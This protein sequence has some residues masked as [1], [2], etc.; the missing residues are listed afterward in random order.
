MKS[1]KDALGNLTGSGYTGV[2][3]TSLTLPVG[4]SYEYTYN[5][6]HR[7]TSATKT[8]NGNEQTANYGYDAFG[9]PT[10][11]ALTA[12]GYTGLMYES[13]AYSSDGNELL[14]VTDMLNGTTSYT[15]DATT[16]LLS[17]VEDANSH[18]TGYI[19]DSRYRIQKIYNDKDS[20]GVADSNEESV[21]YSYTMNELSGI[22]TATTGYTLQH[23]PFGNL[24][25]VKAGNQT[26]ASYIYGS[27]NGKIQRITYG[28]GNY[29]E[30]TYDHLDRVKT[31]K[32]NL[33]F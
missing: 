33:T 6:K 28:N 16:K 18:R 9:N 23:D 17:A 8:E 1:A 11:A 24:K 3:L 14:S 26:L 20:D 12:E 30:Y 13:A 15:F 19:Y 7:V 31:V 25:S 21:L 27:Y 29:E 4:S 10:S 5:T 32:Y 2:D 22:Q